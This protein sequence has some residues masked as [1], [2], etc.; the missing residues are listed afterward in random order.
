MIG[1][2]IFL[3]FSLPYL[4]HDATHD[5]SSL[6]GW[7][8]L[9]SGQAEIDL[10]AARFAAWLASGYHYQDLAGARHLQFLDGL[11]ELRWLDWVEMVLLG[12]GLIYLVVRLIRAGAARGRDGLSDRSVG[13]DVVL[14]AWLLIPV[15]LQTR[16]SQPV[17]PHYFILL[18][19]VQH[20]II[21]LVLSDALDWM[22]GRFGVR[23]GS[24]FV[25]GLVLL[26]VA[27]GVWQI[28]LGQSF[29]RF[30]ARYDTPG[31]YGPI[32]GPLRRAATAAGEAAQAHGAEILI[33]AQSDDPIWG[34][35][36]AAFDVLLPRDV[37]HRFVDGQEALVY[38]LRPAVYITTPGV[39]EALVTL[40]EQTNAVA[41]EQIA[42][43]GVDP[44]QVFRRSNVSRDDVL[45]GMATLDPP[46]RLSNGVELLA[47]QFGGEL[48]PGGAVEFLLAWWLY[49]SS[50]P[51]TGTDYHTFAHLVDGEGQRWG[52]QDLVGFP[53]SS[54]RAGDLVLTR[55]QIESGAEAAP[56]E[57]WVNL[58]MYSYPDVVAAPVLDVAGNPAGDFTVVG[59]VVLR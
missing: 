5:W 10:D 29:L 39:D 53:T 52:Q 34:N 25:A 1:L 51:P 26:V 17:F 44:Y 12:A 7:L 47:Y 56:G 54:W 3:L 19:P 58:G 20:L 30:V 57:Y 2:L 31:G 43:P 37:P 33:V 50:P 4:Y 46:R 41:L 42:A 28:Y 18:Y 38:P 21:A 49:A 13:R 35:E 27:I 15:A 36:P 14:L 16:H 22:R 6:R 48:Q 32:V 55:F 40:Q 23:L 11:P 45:A 24:V 9:G 59:P 8:D